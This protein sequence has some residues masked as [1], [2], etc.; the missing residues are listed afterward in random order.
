M[1][2]RQPTEFD[3]KFHGPIDKRGC[4]DVLC[5]LLL[6]AFIIGWAVVAVVAF[7]Q[8]DP[9]ILVHPT[10][11]WGQKCGMDEEV[12][13]L[14][15]L[16][17]FDITKCA[18]PDVVLSGCRT[19]QV[20]VKECPNE[21]WSLEYGESLR[22]TADE[23]KA[24]MIC[25]YGIA[26]EIRKYTPRE[27]VE[28]NFCARYI[29]PSKSKNLTQVK[30]WRR[31]PVKNVKSIF[32]R[33][34]IPDP[35]S[36]DKA[37]IDK[38]KGA[39]DQPLI[40]NGIKSLLDFISAK[41]NVE[42]IFE[43]LRAVWLPTITLLVIGAMMSLIWI[44]LMRCF[45]G[46]MVWLSLFGTMGV[47]GYACFFSVTKYL[48]LKGVEEEGEKDVNAN[49]YLDI[50][51]GSQL[52]RIL[53][54]KNTWLT[55]SIAT[56]VVLGILL[57]V[58]L[59]LRSRLSIAVALIKQGA[60]AVSDM[61]F[62]LAWPL[63]PWVLQI[64]VIGIFISIGIYLTSATE[65]L[66]KIQ[67]NCTCG[68][69]ELVKEARCHIE[70]F[71]K[72]CGNTTECGIKN[73]CQFAQYQ[74]LS[75]VGWLHLYNFFGLI[76]LLCFIEDFG[77]MVLAGS[78]AGWYWTFNRKKDLITFPV[79][80]SFSRTF[81][82]H[83]GTI[84]FGSLIISVIK[85]IRFFLEYVDY[86]LRQYNENPIAKAILC[87]C[88]CCFWCLEKFMKFIN[89]NAY[90]MC[91]VYGKNFCTSARDA[92][93]L[94]MRNA[95]RAFVLDKVTDFLL[96]MGKVVIVGGVSILSFYVFS[97][98]YG[99]LDDYI[100]VLHFYFV[101]VIIIAVGTYFISSLFFSVYSMAVDTL[102]LCFLEDC[103]RNDGTPEKPYYMPKELMEILGKKNKKESAK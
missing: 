75:H 44:C 23:M 32:A 2:K 52:D 39:V 34:C 68:V 40:V 54:L 50:E 11:S 99:I 77:E 57:F 72:Q 51:L 8:G 17:F 91:A 92:F 10:D 20:C 96:F 63:V 48:D 82:Y 56:G 49:K 66:W 21:T 76:W 26:D 93:F 27:L 94:L 67:E 59:V 14:P 16:Y 41:E 7:K 4:T 9:S 80:S 47:L 81:R 29:L 83:L 18:Q 95:I 62:T 73:A 58:V 19:P 61:T 90:I 25:R 43:D 45:A 42:Y 70:K 60:S 71:Q 1:T 53:K 15:Y 64:F 87:C 30:I 86:K 101:P 3:A 35:S 100:P 31:N 36:I 12:K 37:V 85:F 79:A 33:R 6:V 78:F 97:G 5:L 55:F 89:R 98:K 88:K 13:N 69:E 74:K 22:Q 46:I 28:K 102:F 24:K 84:A 38:L 65:E 103:E